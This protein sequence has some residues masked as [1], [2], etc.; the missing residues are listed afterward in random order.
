VDGVT[1]QLGAGDVLG[2]VGESGSGKTTVAL[3]LLGY[4]AWNAELRGAVLFRGRDMLKSSKQE[5]RA[6]R[7][8]HI[9]YVPQTLPP[10]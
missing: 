10:P 4:R 1:F 6:Q 5:L 2:L 9:A 7:G 3:S 8:R